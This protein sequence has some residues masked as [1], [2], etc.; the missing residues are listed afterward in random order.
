MHK[1]NMFKAFNMFSKYISLR[2]TNNHDDLTHRSEHIQ[3]NMQFGRQKLLP[4]PPVHHCINLSHL[5]IFSRYAM[6]LESS[7][8]CF[9]NVFDMLCVS[10]MFSWII[11]TQRT[12]NQNRQTHRTYS[13]RKRGKLCDLP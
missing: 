5:V 7:K 12:L 1:K 10:N 9:W 4:R 8:K 11:G 2:Q 6:T 3:E 13:K